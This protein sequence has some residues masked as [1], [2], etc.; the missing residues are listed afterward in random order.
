MEISREQFEE[1]WRPRF[2]TANPERMTCPLWEWM[3]LGKEAPD[4][5]EVEGEAL[6]G[7][8]PY[9]VREHFDISN[10]C[11]SG[12]RPVWTFKRLGMSRTELPDGTVIRIGGEYDDFYDPDFHIYNDVI[13]FRPDGSLEFY[14]YPRDVFPPTDFHSATLVGDRIIVIGRLG[15]QGEREFGHTPVY[16]LHLSEMRFEPLETRGEMP[17]WISHHRATL[18]GSAI[19]V[20]GGDLNEMREAEVIRK[21]FD[22]FTLDLTTGRWERLTRNDW[23]QFTIRDEHRLLHLLG[24]PE[25]LDSIRGHMEQPDL[26]CSL[27]MIQFD[28]CRPRGIEHTVTDEDVE[29]YTMRIRVDGVPV[30]IRILS[31]FEVVIEGEMAEA[32]AVQVVE[33]IAASIRNTTGRRYVIER[34]A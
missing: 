16:A 26:L 8:H 7:F 15:Y 12:Y 34:N 17:G 3:I 11:D 20:S 23:P 5:E 28:D 24:P 6:P 33:A 2:G 10:D 31:D 22:T 32:R 9:E 21:N 25:V 27:V 29:T 1:Q 4:P 18:D 13:V 19:T 14:G 30:R